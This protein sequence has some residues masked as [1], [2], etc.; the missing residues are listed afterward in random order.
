MLPNKF[1]RC[2]PT[3]P[4][5]FLGGTQTSPEQGPLSAYPPTYS[6]PPH[7]SLL[8]WNIRANSERIQHWLQWLND[9]VSWNFISIRY[10]WR[11]HRWE[12][13]GNYGQRFRYGWRRSHTAWP[14]Q[15]L[16][17]FVSIGKVAEVSIF[18]VQQCQELAL[19][20]PWQ[21]WVDT[22]CPIFR[23]IK[24]WWSV[25]LLYMSNA[26]LSTVLLR[27]LTR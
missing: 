19:A 1:T 11:I 12:S 2:R 14:W 7:E 23:I 26:L 13:S 4:S 27:Q 8:P 9:L 16:A 20:P 22:C 6:P 17:C 10:K 24:W 15:M 5:V 21:C 3:S 25:M 18:F